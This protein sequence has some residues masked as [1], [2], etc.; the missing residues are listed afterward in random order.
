M[1]K[2]T[3]NLDLA[4]NE[5]NFSKTL[6]RDF[7]QYPELGFQEF[8]TSKIVAE[9]LS[10]LGYQVTTGL[11][12]T[13][14]V[15]LLPGKLGSPIILLRFDM[16]A[17]P[18]LEK[19]ETEY[20]SKNPGVMHACGHDAHMAIGLT[21]AKILAEKK[22][23]LNATIKLVFQPAEEGLGG[24][25]AM[26]QAGVLKNPKPDYCIGAHVWNEKPLSWVGLTAGPIMAGADTFQIKITGKGGHGGHPHETIDPIPAAAQL[27]LATQTIPS[28][29]LSPLDNAVISFCSMNGGTT[30]N[31]IPDEV[32]LSGTIRTYLPSVRATVIKRMEEIIQHTAQAFQCQ[33]NFIL[34]SVT[35][36]VINDKNVVNIIKPPITE[37]IPNIK[38]DTELKSMVSEDFAFFL[39]EIPGCFI[40]VG[41]AKADKSLNF[42]HHH[43]KFDIDEG[44]LP[45]AVA[46]FLEAVEA[47]T[48]FK[49][50]E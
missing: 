28:R 39:N 40:F 15:G 33:A 25:E 2:M 49:I 7:H 22:D 8:R 46:V 6:R 10:S 42:G 17:L 21:V 34:D 24:A 11:A 30:F 12:K 44:V 37:N 26:I 35:P 50:K 9:T 38:I 14:V 5:F 27:I 29:N 36:A 4:I 45:I 31:V 18:V 3:K 13:G 41:S 48:A 32:T 16:D 20:L 19:N 1:I 23:Q 43:P 47:L